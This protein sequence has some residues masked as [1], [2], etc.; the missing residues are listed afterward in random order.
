M[1]IALIS[2]I[3]GNLQALEAVLADIDRLNVD[4]VVC[5]G[6][7]ATLG[8]SPREVMQQVRGLGIPCILGNHEEA[9]LYPERALEYGIQSNLLST[10]RWCLDLLTP[11]DVAY[12]RSAI[13]TAN[14]QAGVGSQLFLYHGSPTS[15][16]EGL[17]PDTCRARLDD[18]F[19]ELDATVK[20]AAGGH[21]HVQMLL[22]HRQHLIINPGSVGCA[23][24]HPPTP[25]RPPQYFPV[26]EYAIM[27]TDAQCVSVELRQVNFDVKAFAR[28][29]L[30]SSIPLKDW[31]SE[32]FARLET[33]K[34]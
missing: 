26:A 22:Q 13:P 16:T 14:I 32:Q 19:S 7:V 33:F 21:T 15:S 9:L 4:R 20:V 30:D 27:T 29:I 3:H 1:K 10:I 34:E 31:W 25:K 23:F 8:P 28:A 12:L 11:S 18:L 24:L 6:D 2:D 5:L 17:Y